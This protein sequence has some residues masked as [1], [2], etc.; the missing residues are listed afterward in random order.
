MNYSLKYSSQY[1]FGAE[2]LNV[3]FGSDTPTTS[4]TGPTSGRINKNYTFDVS[5]VDP[6]GDDVY[7][8]IKWGD[9]TNT[10]W[11]GPYNSGEVIQVSHS[12]SERINYTI[13]AKAKDINGYE[14]KEQPLQ[15]TL[16]YKYK[17]IFLFIKWLFEQLFPNDF[18]FLH[19]LWVY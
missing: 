7:L 18:L 17:P 13:K 9:G 6:Q 15:I 14:G 11:L 12:F 2:T 8:Y 19:Q 5:A 1:T 3:T 4:I 16:I 10:E